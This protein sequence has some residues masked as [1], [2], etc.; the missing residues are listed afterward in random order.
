MKNKQKN[1]LSLFFFVITASSIL[2]PISIFGLTDNEEYKFGIF[3]STYLYKDFSIN[4][5][6]STFVDFFGPGLNL[7][8]GQGLF[9]PTNI[10][11]FNL[12]LFYLTTIFLICFY[13]LF[14]SKIN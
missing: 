6:F 10:F 2:I 8:I 13:N 9:F 5:I 1:Y 14:I 11:S 12:K 4:N 3:S 7:P